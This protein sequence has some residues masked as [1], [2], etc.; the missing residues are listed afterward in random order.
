MGP[1][2]I[3]LFGLDEGESFN[4]APDMTVVAPRPLVLKFLI[5]LSKSFPAV[6]NIY[7]D[8]HGYT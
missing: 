2:L 1:S 5:C 8:L 7:V 3:V 4:Q 6:T